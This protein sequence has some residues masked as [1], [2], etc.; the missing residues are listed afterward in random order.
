M[1]YN[2]NR[3][4]WQFFVPKRT[5][6]CWKSS[7]RVTIGYSGT[8][9]NPLQCSVAVTKVLCDYR[10][11]SRDRLNQ[12]GC[13]LYRCQTEVIAEH[14][15][16]QATV[17][18]ASLLFETF[19][20]KYF[21]FWTYYITPI[22]GA[23]WAITKR[24]WSWRRIPIEICLEMNFPCRKMSECESASMASAVSYEFANKLSYS[25]LIGADFILIR[26]CT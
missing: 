24:G 9:L 8:F 1:D 23:W 11:T 14:G 26:E 5:S 13:T 21:Y 6:L 17:T 25:L 7:D 22:L 19:P 10:W 12:C 15:S 2:D 18:S 16:H 3:L 4:Q 20:T